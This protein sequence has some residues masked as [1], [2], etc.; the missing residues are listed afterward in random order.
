RLL[1]RATGASFVA[2]DDPSLQNLYLLDLNSGAVV[3]L[4]F[5]V[6]GRPPNASVPQGDIS[7]DGQ[8]LV[9][10]SDATNVADSS[11]AGVFLQDL[12]SVETVRVS[13]PLGTLERPQGSSGSRVRI[14][15]DGSALAF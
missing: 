7:N 14:S 11:E 3:Q 13:A 1:F 8:R 4:P 15:S 12:S 6:D 10:A 2:G 5:T 9:F